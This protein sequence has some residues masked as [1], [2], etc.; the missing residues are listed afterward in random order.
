MSIFGM[1]LLMILAFTGFDSIA[2]NSF[3]G[4]LLILSISLSGTCIAIFQLVSLVVLWSQISEAGFV[5][6]IVGGLGNAGLGLTGLIIIN[7]A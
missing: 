1:F 3:R 2:L 4:V 7:L 5:M 6:G